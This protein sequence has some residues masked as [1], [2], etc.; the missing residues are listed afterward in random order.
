[1]AADTTPV[2]LKSTLEN[3][4]TNDSLTAAKDRQKMLMAACYG[5]VDNF[6][7]LNDPFKYQKRTFFLLRK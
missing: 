7:L 5:V 2:I 1:M 3:L 6:S 4:L